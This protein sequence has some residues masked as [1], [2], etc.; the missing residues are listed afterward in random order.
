MRPEPAVEVVISTDSPEQTEEFGE[1]VGALLLPGDLICLS[2][3]LGAGKTCLVRGIGR[4]W[5]ALERPTSPTFTLVNE[6]HRHAD[7]RRL[8]HVDCY[9]LEDVRD[10]WSTGLEDLLESNEMIVIE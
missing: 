7:A 3:D 6:Y 10:A 1:S 9:R 4:G 2:G 8:V 5:G